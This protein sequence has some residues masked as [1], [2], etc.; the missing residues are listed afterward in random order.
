DWSSDV[1]SSDLGLV[2]S[3][4]GLDGAGK[5]TL[6]AW[7]RGELER[8]H[9]G[10][11]VLHLADGVGASLLRAARDGLQRLVGRHNGEP[12]RPRWAGRPRAPGLRGLVGRIRDAIVW[13]KHL[14]RVLYPVD[15][16]V[17]LAIRFYV[18]TVRGRDRKSTRLNSSH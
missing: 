5:S 7:L 15:L 9:R 16:A 1:C 17:F 18:A 8:R 14:R 11:T 13:S 10:V 3:F 6:V 4:S 12:P 2:I